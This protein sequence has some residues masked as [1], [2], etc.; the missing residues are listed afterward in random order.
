MLFIQKVAGLS[1]QNCQWDLQQKNKIFMQRVWSFC[2]H[3][4]K[5]ITGISSG[6]FMAPHLSHFART[7]QTF[8]NKPLSQSG[9]FKRQK[10]PLTMLLFLFPAT[11]FKRCY[12]EWTSNK[13]F[14]NSYFR[15]SSWCSSVVNLQPQVSSTA[16]NRGTTAPTIKKGMEFLKMSEMEKGKTCLLSWQWANNE[17]I[18]SVGVSACSA[19]Q[20]HNKSQVFSTD[21]N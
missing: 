13:E 4:S 2:T 12:R 6:K 17:A 7:S 8:L 5:F 15:G 16:A 11:L 20:H 9:I 3:V 1:L 10:T 21:I 14:G 18:V 19:A